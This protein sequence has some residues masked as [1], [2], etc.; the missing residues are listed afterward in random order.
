MK[1]KNTTLGVGFLAAA[2]LGFVVIVGLVRS[3]FS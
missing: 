2:I 3:A 1:S